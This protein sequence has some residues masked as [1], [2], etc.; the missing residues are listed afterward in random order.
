LY[1]YGFRISKWRSFDFV[2]L[3]KQWTF[4]K[5]DCNRR[6]CLCWIWVFI[7]TKRFTEK[8]VVKC[9]PTRG[10]VK[11][12]WRTSHMVYVNSDVIAGTRRKIRSGVWIKCS[13]FSVL[14][15][16]FCLQNRER[17]SSSYAYS[18]ENT[19]IRRNEY[20]SDIWPL[21]S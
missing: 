15:I 17:C 11:F 13:Y 10:R 1:E 2:F 7:S 12:M 21:S 4:L 5:Y 18:H 16:S 3:K 14:F 6:F 8:F 20:L 19:R 9:E